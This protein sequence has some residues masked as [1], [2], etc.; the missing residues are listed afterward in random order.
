M[1]NVVAQMQRIICDLQKDVDLLRRSSADELMKLANRNADL[2]K[3][4][5]MLERQLKP[6]LLVKKEPVDDEESPPED[7]RPLQQ[8]RPS[9]DPPASKNERAEFDDRTPEEQRPTPSSTS[10]PHADH[11]APDARPPLRACQVFSIPPSP[12]Q[13]EQ[14]QRY[15][16]RISRTK[17][18]ALQSQQ[19]RP[20]PSVPRQR[21]RPQKMRNIGPVIRGAYARAEHEARLGSVAAIA[22]PAEDVEDRLLTRRNRPRRSCSWDRDGM[23][24]GMTAPERRRKRSRSRSAGPRNNPST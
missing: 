6:T 8:E 22:M 17:L 18:A 12:S 10:A 21:D 9:S 14:R 1:E 7:Q 4:V 15:I 11:P 5:E 2:E 20:A 13:T 3:R 24:A 16:M 23:Y 19:A